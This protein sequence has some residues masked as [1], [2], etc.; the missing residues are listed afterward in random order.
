M[1]EKT[2]RKAPPTC[3]IC[4][5]MLYFMMPSGR[6]LRCD[7]CN[8]YFINENGKAGRETSSPYVRKDVLY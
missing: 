2:K 4:N 8:K 3:P 5:G 6:T 1:T 7:R